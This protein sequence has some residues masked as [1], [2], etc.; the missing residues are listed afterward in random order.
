MD[1]FKEKREKRR[2]RVSIPAMMRDATGGVLATGVLEDVSSSGARFTN[3]SGNLEPGTRGVL[4]LMD[5]SLA[6]RTVSDDVIE[7]EAEVVRKELGGYALRFLDP[8]RDLEALLER[9]TGRRAIV[10]TDE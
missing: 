7:L 1:D 4:R 9:A 8:A 6:L 3:A 2:Y 5:L 10:P